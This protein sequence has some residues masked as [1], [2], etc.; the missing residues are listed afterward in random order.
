M[1]ATDYLA[2]KRDSSTTIDFRRDPPQR[3]CRYR[4]SGPSSHNMRAVS[5]TQPTPATTRECRA[6]AHEIAALIRKARED[7]QLTQQALAQRMN[8]KQA[9]VARW[10]SGTTLV[11]MPTL[12]LIA[13]ALGCELI[14]HFGPRADT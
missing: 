5:A 3:T 14:V 6:T 12:S 2:T 13:E 9:E 4:W 10:E 1:S 8:K 7:R 11:K